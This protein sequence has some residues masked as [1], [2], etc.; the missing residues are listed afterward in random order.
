[1]TV[2]DTQAKNFILL[3]RSVKL[4]C[5][6][7]SRSHFLDLFRLYQWEYIRIA[8]NKSIHGKTEV[9]NDAFSSIEQLH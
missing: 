9:Q 5:I 8:G 2:I 3:Q 4:N 1:M 6:T 7:F